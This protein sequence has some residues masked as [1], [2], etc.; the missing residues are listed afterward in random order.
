AC[1]RQRVL[2]RLRGRAVLSAQET[3]P[4]LRVGVGVVEKT[5]PKA[6]GV[7]VL[8]PVLPVQLE[9]RVGVRVAAALLTGALPTLEREWFAKL[10]AERPSDRAQPAISGGELRVAPQQD[11]LGAGPD[12]EQH[13]EVAVL[14]QKVAVA[15]AGKTSKVRG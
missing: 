10:D 14:A 6:V 2:H 4:R 13:V 9:S 15:V 3:S 11:A 12:A 7:A 1:R 5:A 8:S